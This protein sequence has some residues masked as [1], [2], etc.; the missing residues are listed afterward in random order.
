ML[1]HT[2][3]YRY[4]CTLDCSIKKIYIQEK[5][6]RYQKGKLEAVNRKRADNTMVIKKKDRQYNGSKEKGQTIQGL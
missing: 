3:S 6:W 2:I 5:V 4:K 1:W